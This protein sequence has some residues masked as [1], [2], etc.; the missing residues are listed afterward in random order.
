MLNV[1][2]EVIG[3]AAVALL[4]ARFPGHSQTVRGLGRR[5]S[6]YVVGRSLRMEQAMGIKPTKLWL[7]FLDTYAGLACVRSACEIPRA[8]GQAKRTGSSGRG[9]VSL[10]GAAGPAGLQKLTAQRIGRRPLGDRS[11]A[12]L[13]RAV[14]AHDWRT[15]SVPLDWYPGLG[16]YATRRVR[17]VLRDCP[18]SSTAEVRGIDVVTSTLPHVISLRRC[19]ACPSTLCRTEPTSCAMAAVSRSVRRNEVRARRCISASARPS[20]DDR[21]GTELQR[22]AESRAKFY[23]DQGCAHGTGETGRL[24]GHPGT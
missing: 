11:T 16:G 20:I 1:T 7:L 24:I 9:V 13:Q 21:R 19:S 5:S 6:P 23:L 17:S 22:G 3:W 14:S 10:D 2:I 15:I 18:D 8:A 12:G 4:N